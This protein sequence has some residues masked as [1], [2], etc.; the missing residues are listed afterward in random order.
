MP[1]LPPFYTPVSYS[2]ESQRGFI[3][4]PSTE[5]GAGWGEP[6]QDEAGN[7]ITPG[8]LGGPNDRA[9]LGPKRGQW[10]TTRTLSLQDVGNI[11]WK[12][13]WKNLARTKRKVLSWH[14]PPQRYWNDGTFVYGSSRFHRHIYSDGLTIGIAP[15]PVMGAAIAEIDGQ[16]TL[17]AIVKYGPWFE[18][19]YTTTTFLSVLRDNV[20]DD[21]DLY[22]DYAD[23]WT[24]IGYPPRYVDQF[25]SVDPEAPW[26]FST[27]GLHAR[28]MKRCT[29]THDQLGYT[30]TEEL[31]RE[32][33]MSID[34]DTG[35]AQF[36]RVDGPGFVEEAN[37]WHTTIKAKRYPNTLY[38]QPDTESASGLEHTFRE[39]RTDAS[40]EM[41]GSNKIAVDYHPDDEVWVY[42][43]IEGSYKQLI[44]QYYTIN[45]DE[46]V[47]GP[48]A[49]NRTGSD[50]GPLP[51]PPDAGIFNPHYVSHT[52]NITSQ[53]RLMIGISP[54]APDST[55]GDVLLTDGMFTKW[56]E[57]LLG[58]KP[59]DYPE[60]LLGFVQTFNT[61]LKY[62]DLRT[63]LICGR[64]QGKSGDTTQVTD[65]NLSAVDFIWGGQIDEYE[66]PTESDNKYFTFR[67]EAAEEIAGARFQD[68]AY[69]NAL[70]EDTD[71]QWSYI[72]YSGVVASE[73]SDGSLGG[74]GWADFWRVWLAGEEYPYWVGA[75]TTQILRDLRSRFVGVAGSTE[76]GECLI[77]L[78]EITPS[79]VVVDHYSIGVAGDPVAILSA[80]R[81]RQGGVI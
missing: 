56:P 13:P 22:R 23:A 47:Y 55:Y 12:G 30:L 73:N 54:L 25:P 80:P 2:T 63:G 29:V 3:V 31:Y 1:L 36:Q 35:S 50:K 27:D 39:T 18:E 24:L 20:P 46:E 66:Y 52:L 6:Y 11:D 26:F 37:T 21:A 62:L 76:K 58:P 43:W 53:M 48:R 44:W 5:L 81:I 45:I 72:S 4:R 71:D 32:V 49:G 40:R 51:K 28:T 59:P 33:R 10:T 7:A 41:E 42:G 14:G 78:E 16:E 68:W 67:V 60:T 8:T 38:V 69:V 65:W 70:P 77:I 34:R 15:G 19:V 17:V 79:G 75:T 64:T 74:P 57:F 9:Y 61:Y